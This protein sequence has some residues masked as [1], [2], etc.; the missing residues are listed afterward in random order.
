MP[1]YFKSI[2]MSS[3]ESDFT[4]RSIERRGRGRRRNVIVSLDVLLP[5]LL[6]VRA[7]RT[8]SI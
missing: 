5:T 4:T 1:V 3:Y 7:L 8:N 6:R 2:V